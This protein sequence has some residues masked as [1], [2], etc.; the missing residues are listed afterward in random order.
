MQVNFSVTFTMNLIIRTGFGPITHDI[1]FNPNTIVKGKALSI[2][3]VIR[4]EEL[5]SEN[6]SNLIR[7]SVI[8]QTS[9]NATPYKVQLHVST[10][11][12]L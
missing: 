4:V 2:S 6:I 7:C 3:H 1:K 10:Y 8:S 9:V 12:L 5:R 11:I